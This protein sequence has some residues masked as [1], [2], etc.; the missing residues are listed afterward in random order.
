MTGSISTHFELS[1]IAI[2][3]C[4]L[5]AASAVDQ[6]ARRQRSFL[7]SERSRAIRASWFPSEMMVSRENESDWQ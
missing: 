1:A 5:S 7:S 4:Y 6:H 3:R 2:K